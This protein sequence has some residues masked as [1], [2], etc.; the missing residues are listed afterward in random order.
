M[1][2]RQDRHIVLEVIA[3]VFK[4]QVGEH[5]YSLCYDATAVST[6]FGATEINA[7]FE[8]IGKNPLHHVVLVWS[9]LRTHHP[10]L[11]IEEVSS[12]YTPANAKY[13]MET[14]FK[15]LHE[16]TRGWNHEEAE[17]NPNPPSA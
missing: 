17:A 8:P 4:L 1:E 3:P 6:F 2:N 7:L 16:Q 10:D 9:G 13:L 14:V 15:A 12:W 11:Q 5:T